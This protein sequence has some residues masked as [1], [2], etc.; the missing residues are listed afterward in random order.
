MAV[1]CV[2]VCCVCEVTRVY[3]IEIHIRLRHQGINLT[4]EVV[5]CLKGAVP[6]YDLP[7]P[8]EQPRAYQ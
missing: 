8:S 3:C 6:G 1:W 5:D 2:Y 7:G 4:N